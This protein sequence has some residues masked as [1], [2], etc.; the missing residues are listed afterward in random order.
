SSYSSPG[1]SVHAEL[2]AVRA[3]D[4]LLVTKLYR[5]PV[6]PDME[7]RADLLKRL[8]H[9]TLRPLTLI[10][11]PAGYGKTTLASMWLEASPYPSVWISLD[12]ADKDPRIFTSYLVSG[13]QR[14]FPDA[15][16]KTRGLLQATAMPSPP[17]VARYLLNDLDTIGEPFV[18]ALD[19]LH[20]ISEPLIFALLSELLH[21]PSPVL[22]LLL[23]TRRD[24]PL[25]IAS[26]RAH[27]QIAE[28]RARDLRF[29]V[30]ETTSLLSK[31]LQRNVDE[32]TA[33]G[34]TERTE[35]WVTALR[36]A[37]LSLRNRDESAALV[38]EIPVSNRYL[39]DYLFAE[40]LARLDPVNQRWLLASSLLDRLSA[41]LIEAV[42]RADGTGEQNAMTGHSFLDWLQKQNLFLI[43]LDDQHQWFR[44]H[45][46]FQHLLQR[47]LQGRLSLEDRAGLHRRAAAWFGRNTMWNDAIRH[48]VA[49]GETEAAIQIVAQQ[50]HHFI[51]SENWSELERWMT[52]FPDEVIANDP[53]LS[54]TL[55][56]L[57]VTRGRG[58][59]QMAVSRAANLVA[60]LPDDSPVAQEVR[61]EL[62][63]FEAMI[64]V[65]TGD[66]STVRAASTEALKLL[67]LY[68]QH[69]RSQTIAFHAFGC[70]MMGE[71]EQGNAILEEAFR[72]PGLPASEKGRLLCYRSLICFMDGDLFGAQRSASESIRWT[73]NCGLIETL[74]E[75][76]YVSG[77]A[78]YLSNELTMAESVLQTIMHEPALAPPEY[79]AQ[80]AITLARIYLAQGRS[81]RAVEV[82]ASC[83]ANLEEQDST[84]VLDELRAFQIEIALAQEDVDLARRLGMVIDFD[85][86]RVIWFYPLQLTPVK[87]LL[88]ERNARDAKQALSL[89]EQIDQRLLA[90][91]RRIYR[92]DV[93]A[94]K[95]L[96]YHAQDNW[97]AA[98][99]QLIAA[100]DL[101]QAA[102][103][104]RYFV[105]LG[106]PMARLLQHLERERSALQPSITAFVSK[107]LAAFPTHVLVPTPMTNV[108]LAHQSPTPGA[109]IPVGTEDLTQRECEVLEYLATDLTPSQIAEELCI[110]LST[111]RT[112]TRNIYGK[113]SVHNRMEA[114]H[115]ARELAET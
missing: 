23:I 55:A 85:M 9:Q 37:A 86:N 110:S 81:E 17:V 68:L 22:H 82:I 38:D 46:L 97:S 18:L 53:L 101:A 66:P 15:N 89:L 24:P 6:T 88:A 93:L 58:N 33:A 21:H 5:P 109:T 30:Q 90:M 91:N 14:V 98:R 26:L 36:L 50:R 44:Y 60:S 87:L 70:Q 16:L 2:M 12:E 63:Y 105:D 56:N 8:G 59:Q 92:I 19:D 84:Y 83:T 115:R 76:R 80:T 78:H 20:R 114:M 67:P 1:G 45:H 103:A 96:A 3:P 48:Y 71:V 111:L 31:L 47:T 99:E 11:A 73:S 29:T 10:S 25:P 79:L 95:A 106:Q 62:A 64:G 51:N 27:G 42:C 77:I 72:N 4:P 49:A 28:V 41:S 52:W 102:G 65:Y 75:A 43:P 69:I 57:P 40:V 113:L 7:S 74:N 39:N 54:I 34:W 94:L 100:L 35:G 32:A 104:I 61:G 112:H 13:I 107:L 108:P